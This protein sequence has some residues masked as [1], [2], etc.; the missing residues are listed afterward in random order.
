MCGH[1]SKSDKII[2]INDVIKDEDNSFD[3]TPFDE[4]RNI[5]NNSIP[6]KSLLNHKRLKDKTLII[7]YLMFT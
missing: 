6:N 1:K 4:S 3:K 7:Y 5:Q 2:N